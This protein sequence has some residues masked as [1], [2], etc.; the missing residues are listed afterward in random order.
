MATYKE[1]F[2]LRV[3][4]ENPCGE[5]IERMR[6][7]NSVNRNAMTSRREL[8]QRVF[9]RLFE[10]F[11]PQGW[12]PA[13]TPT[14]VIIGAILTQNT[15]WKNVKQSIACL[16]RNNLLDFEALHRIS[17]S[18][19]ALLIRSSGYYNQKARKLKAFCEHLQTRWQGDLSLFLSQETGP[20]RKELLQ[21]YGIG[22]ETADSILLYA[23]FQPSFVV[24]TYTC[25]IFHRYGW[26]S[27]DIGY[28][29]LRDYFMDCLEPDVEYFQEYHA[30]LVR[31][32]H[33]YCRRK[34]F[35]DFCPLNGW[36]EG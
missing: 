18:E 31:A 9:D 10:A 3:I 15:A 17:E 16:R 13:K 33:L 21:I 8:I 24:D 27:E 2:L 35:C 28:D 11:G 22:P 34:P 30:L 19:L 5:K 20:L 14:E 12:W 32:G 23:A 29:E 1:R 7:S 6:Y 26:V 4:L 25:R 36:T